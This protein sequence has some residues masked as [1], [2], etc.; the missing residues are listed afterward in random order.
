MSAK[1]SNPIVYEPLAQMPEL[2]GSVEIRS[3]L[4]FPQIEHQVRKL[5][6]QLAPAYQVASVST[7]ELLRDHVIAQDRLLT[8]LSVLFGLLGTALA[9]VGI[10]GLIS[11]SVTRRTR[12]IGIRMSIGAQR[13]EVLLLFLHEVILLVAFGAVIGL[14]LALALWRPLKS[15][16][17]EVPAADPIAI[18]ITLLLIVVGSLAASFIPAGRATRVNPVEALRYE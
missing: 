18:G 10:Y 7:M 11:Y 6:R 17:Y 14:P 2:A 16:L 9:L 13:R 8:F 3:R 1:T 5:V 12:E 15:F 4:P